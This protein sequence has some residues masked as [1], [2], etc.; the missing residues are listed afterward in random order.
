MRRAWFLTSVAVSLAIT[1]PAVAQAPPGESTL[2][3]SPG[4]GRSTSYDAKYFAQYAPRT[5]LDIVSRIPGFSLELGNSG[6][7]GFSG[8]A[9]NV[10]IDGQR[11]SS[12]SES[13][14]IPVSE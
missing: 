11:P 3:A 5:A 6:L 8:A 14:R 7:R 4:N 13:P 10:V 1:S 12:K 9:G 2:P